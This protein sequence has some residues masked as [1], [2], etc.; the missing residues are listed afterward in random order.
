M[1]LQTIPL[2]RQ[3]RGQRTL[4][5]ISELTGIHRGSL[6]QIEHGERIPKL[7]QIDQLERGY[8]PQANWWRV[9]LVEI[10]M[11]ASA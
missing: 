10:P 3:H 4:A 5:Q 1:H 7:T 6:S 2:F 11:E 8:G 9:R